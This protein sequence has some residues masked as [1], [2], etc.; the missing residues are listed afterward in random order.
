MGIVFK[1][2]NKIFLSPPK[3]KKNFI[4]IWSRSSLI[5]KEYIGLRFRVYQGKRFINITVI[6]EMVGHRFGEFSPTRVR[7]VYKKKRGN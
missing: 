7:H 1:K 4:K 6:D 3:S 5:L 2:V